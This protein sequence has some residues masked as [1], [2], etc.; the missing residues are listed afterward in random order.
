[1]MDYR[2]EGPGPHSGR[3]GSLARASVKVVK[4]HTLF[5][6]GCLFQ[7]PVPD[8]SVQLELELDP[9]GGDSMGG[10][11]SRLSRGKCIKSITGLQYV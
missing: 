9:S 3:G 10:R 5:V 7:I 1:M 11:A 8:W 2:S 4:N 6:D